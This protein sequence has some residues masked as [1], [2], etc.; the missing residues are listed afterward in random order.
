MESGGDDRHEESG[1]ALL[2]KLGLPAEVTEPVRLHVAAKRFLVATE[3]EGYPLSPSS[4]ASL[5]VQ[6]GAMGEEEVGRFAGE[7]FSGEAVRVRRY[8]DGAKVPGAET[9][10]LEHYRG[11]LV[12]F[13]SSTQQ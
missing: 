8:D 13:L 7:E 6:G 12:A 3:P 1:A 10:T 11:I 2:R 9:P 4:L 5:A